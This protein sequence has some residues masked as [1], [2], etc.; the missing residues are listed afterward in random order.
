M[1]GLP[2]LG[3]RVIED[4][5]GMAE[6]DIRVRHL[7]ASVVWLAILDARAGDASARDFL[8]QP[9]P[10]VLRAAGVNPGSWPR[11]LR[12]L[13][14][15]WAAVDAARQAGKAAPRRMLG[16]RAGGAPAACAAA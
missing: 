7:W 9:A 13:E 15:A 2:G 16:R 5:P 12:R 8:R 1:S 10:G 11:A 4:G 6:A 3:E 14:A